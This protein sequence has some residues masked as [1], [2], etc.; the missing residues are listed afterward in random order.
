MLLSTGIHVTSRCVHAMSSSSCQNIDIP[1]F[2]KRYIS[3]YKTQVF[4]SSSEVVVTVMLVVR[5]YGEGLVANGVI[6]TSSFTKVS[7]CS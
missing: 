7:Q 6:F 1:Y 5:I 4:V 2:V 3:R